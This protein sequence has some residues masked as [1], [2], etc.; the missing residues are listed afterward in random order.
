[1]RSFTDSAATRWSSSRAS[2]S[3]PVN[4]S[5]DVRVMTSRSDQYSRSERTPWASIV[6]IVPG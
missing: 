3:E 5:A 6:T 2:S 1:M 4:R